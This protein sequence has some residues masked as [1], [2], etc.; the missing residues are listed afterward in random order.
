MV[1]IY[2]GIVLAMIF[3]GFAFRRKRRI[4]IPIMVMSF[5]LDLTSV[6]YLELARDV[7]F[8]AYDTVSKGVMQIHLFFAVVTLVG[9]GIAMYTGRKIAKGAPVSALHRI[10]A[11]CFLTARAG[12]FVTSFW[13]LE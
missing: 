9:Y 3:V 4:H 8:K 5:V 10:N 6:L 1:Q 2:S 11:F 12:V 7:I 13:V